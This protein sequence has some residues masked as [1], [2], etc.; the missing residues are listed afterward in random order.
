M[1]PGAQAVPLASSARRLP[2][3]RYVNLSPQWCPLGGCVDLSHQWC[4]LGGLPCRPPL[5]S[6]EAP[7]SMSRNLH[8]DRFTRR[9]TSALLPNRY[10]RKLLVRRGVA[11]A[12][13]GEGSYY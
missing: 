1:L 8:S 6:A 9:A 2:W 11:R 10:E 4:P 13:G 3:R 12:T 7:Y 5:G